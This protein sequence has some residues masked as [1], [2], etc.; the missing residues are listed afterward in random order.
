MGIGTT[1]PASKLEVHNGTVTISSTTSANLIINANAS[2][3]GNSNQILFADNGITKWALGG[4][5]IGGAGT[6]N[7]SLYNYN[8]ASNALTISNSTNNVGI[9]TTTPTNRL[10]VVTGSAGVTGYHS[11]GVVVESSSHNY[12]N[13][14]APDAYETGILFGKPQYNLSGE[15]IYNNSST[16]NGFQFRTNSGIT[17]MVLTSDG[18]VGIGTTAPAPYPLKI[19]GDLDIEDASTQ[20]DWGL[21]LLTQCTESP[22]IYLGI[23][24]TEESLMLI[25]ALIFL[26]QTNA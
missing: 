20:G 26:Y 8:T 16:L 17:Q 6:N 1:T 11:A 24:V 13:L 23:I 15:I 12:I 9:G 14:L 2:A 4:S 3:T 5:N 25:P 7:V 10:H 19:K 21:E 18:H 22:C